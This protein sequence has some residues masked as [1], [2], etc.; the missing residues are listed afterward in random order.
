LTKIIV[1]G[2]TTDVNHVKL[3]DIK[4]FVDSEQALTFLDALF[5]GTRGYVGISL[6]GTGARSHTE[7]AFDYW[8]NVRSMLTSEGASWW[9]FCADDHARWN[10][11][12]QVGSTLKCAPPR[13]KRGRQSDALELL[14]VFADLDVG[15]TED[16][17]RDT[18]ELRTFLALLPEPTLMVASGS[19]G[20]HPYWLYDKPHV[21]QD[22][23]QRH[24]LD[25][26]YDMLTAK[27]SEFGRRIDHVQD[28]ARIMRIPGTVR[29]P[30]RGRDGKV[31]T[32]TAWKPV[33]LV[34]DGGPR[35]KHGELLELTEPYR[36]KAV[37]HH[38]ESR[39]TWKTGRSAQ[40]KWLENCGL[41]HVA[42]HLLE[43]QLNTEQDWGPL[44]KAAGWQLS[45]DNRGS[46]G[47]T[48]CRYWMRPGK[49][50]NDGGPSASTDFPGTNV[51]YVYTTDP[52]V[53]PALTPTSS[54]FTNIMTK[55]SFALHFLAGGDEVKLARAIH[56]GN[57]VIL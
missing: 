32:V 15:K 54:R 55:Y 40:I 30:K 21:V 27:A 34:T 35:Y 12:A 11:Y 39:N 19:G 1:S 41:S 22:V 46:G 6:I 47:S 56:K 53:M 18:A 7:H 45:R 25:G 28:Y 16:T 49:E 37:V 17:F 24:E 3:S 52:L 44:M 36:Q 4:P 13:F 8:V 31:D 38:G 5:S 20:L 26:W 29:W 42:R 43:E 33:T 50:L 9:K 48:D 2:S 57:G 23:S 14:G 51:A 10:A